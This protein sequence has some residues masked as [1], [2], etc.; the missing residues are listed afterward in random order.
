MIQYFLPTI[1]ALGVITSYE[2]TQQNKIRNK[3]IIA[4][5][6]L[7]LI[8]HLILYAL[9]LVNQQY[10]ANMLIQFSI[11]MIVGFF[12]YY[13]NW[14]GAGD[15][16]LY[17]AYIS[18]IPL[19]SYKF[20]SMPFPVFALLINTIIPVFVYLV[21]KLLIKTSSKQKMQALKQV[22]N[23][24]YIL[25]ALISVFSLSW[26]TQLILTQFNIKYTV[27][28]GIAGIIVL[29]KITQYL[30]E[31]QALPLMILIS[32]IRIFINQHYLITASFLVPFM[33]TVAGYAVVRLVLE[34]LSSIFVEKKSIYELKEGDVAVQGVTKKG[35]RADAKTT[36]AALLIEPDTEL[37]AETIEMLKKEHLKGNIH[38]NSMQIQETLPFATSMFMGAMIT[39]TAQGNLIIFLMNTI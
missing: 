27:I 12:L 32:I 24:R 15:A 1:L 29:S 14:W 31:D 26:I 38:F 7:S 11:S 19:T 16:K 13:I 25:S 10:L 37:D 33:L 5:I 39:I 20:L 23:W 9:G 28:Y 36:N 8:I 17:L 4:A 18:L 21:F 3:Y 2:D 34:D 30:F 22:L 6:L 35:I